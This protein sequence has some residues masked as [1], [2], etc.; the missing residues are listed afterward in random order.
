MRF[1]NFI[2]ERIKDRDMFDK[3][4]GL[5][6][7]GDESV[8]TVFGGII[9]SVILCFITIYGVLIFLEMIN[10][11]NTNKSINSV[12]RD[13]YKDPEI[14]NLT[15]E[16]VNFAVFMSVGGTQEVIDPTLFTVSFAQ[17]N[18][19]FDFDVTQNFYESSFSKGATICH[20][21]Y[22]SIEGDFDRFADIYRNKSFCAEDQSF[23]LGG[24]V[25][26]GNRKQY[27]IDVRR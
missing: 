9:S 13:Q 15:A 20:E 5:T 11:E 26:D 21:K 1:F 2:K 19:G 23:Q 7:K 22:P 24:N 8:T 10:R 14:F 17:L 27:M 18:V 4:V 6:Y 3:K 12:V 16:D 25:F